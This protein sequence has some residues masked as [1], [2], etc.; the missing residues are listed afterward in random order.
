M[1]WKQVSFGIRVFNLNFIFSIL[2]YFNPETFM[3]NNFK[4]H[5]I[6]DTLALLQLHTRADRG[7]ISPLRVS[8]L[9]PFKQRALCHVERTSSVAS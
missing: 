8:V 2:T 3:I 7:D 6:I 1:V 9:S 4:V 5:V